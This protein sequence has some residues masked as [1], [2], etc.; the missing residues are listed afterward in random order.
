VTVGG[1]PMNG[2]TRSNV[3]VNADYSILVR[4]RNGFTVFSAPNLPF[5]DSSDN[6]YFLQ[7]GSGAVQRTV[8]SKLRDAVSV[9]DFGA[10][11][12]GVA[13]DTA[14][15]Q[16]AIAQAG[17]GGSVFFPAGTYRTTSTTDGSNRTLFGVG[18]A[19]VI[20]PDAAVTVCILLDSDAN[21]ET[22]F[23]WSTEVRSLFLEGDNTSGAT[24]IFVGQTVTTA[25]Y[26]IDNV[27]V[28][29]FAGAGGFGIKVV[30]SVYCKIQNCEIARCQVNF[31]AKGT[32]TNP[33]T[34]VVE[35]CYIRAADAQGGFVQGAW[36]ITFRNCVFEANRLAGLRVAPLTGFNAIQANIEDCWFEDNQINA[37]PRTS[38]YALELDG[39]AAGATL[40]CDL[41]NVFFGITA[42][43][44]KAIYAINL[45]SS[46]WKNIE[47]RNI[48]NSIAIGQLSTNDV[49]VTSAP[50]SFDWMATID[51][52]D[53]SKVSY[54]PVAFTA[55]QSW[56]PTITCFGSMTFS[57][58][59]IYKAR[60]KVIGKTVTVILNFDGTTGGAASQAFI[61]SLP[62]GVQAADTN[63]W[64]SAIAV[65]A[66]VDVTGYVRSGG[67]DGLYIGRLSGNYSIGGSNG[68]KCSFTFEIQ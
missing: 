28:N 39:S 24:G 5:E 68:A 6:Q 15:I 51:S 43:T 59:N 63:Q 36:Q 62:A 48:A 54:L 56:T 11:G 32:G 29:R 2:S 7:A 50:T 8:Q 64:S 26:L 49:V 41:S 13:D 16:A 12:D 18:E 38:S 4:N 17:N 1:Y 66:G 55:W 46:S 33:T 30:E 52:L 61:V 20:K 44:E 60:Y 58:T 65:D 34:T 40:T 37:S 21:G 67:V 22:G 53:G 42:L 10:V 47:N 3:F 27:T 31:Y 57:V 14:A 35:N 23:A 45:F 19:S 25:N 9:K